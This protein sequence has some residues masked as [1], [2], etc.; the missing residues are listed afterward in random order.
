MKTR[1]VTTSATLGRSGGAVAASD[2]ALRKAAVHAISLSMGKHLGRFAHSEREE[3]E[4]FLSLAHPQQPLLVA[5]PSGNGEDCI[6]RQVLAKC[7][8][9]TT[10]VVV[11]SD[12]SDSVKELYIR[13]RDSLQAV[14]TFKLPGVKLRDMQTYLRNHHIETKLQKNL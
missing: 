14:N 10:R 9:G 7:A 11:V 6:V 8:P 4:R 12:K 5:G 13:L 1:A 3:I 2:F